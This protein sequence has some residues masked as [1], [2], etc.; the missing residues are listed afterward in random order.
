MF[1]LVG[2]HEATIADVPQFEPLAAVRTV[3]VGCSLHG[4]L[5]DSD[6]HELLHHRMPENDR[7]LCRGNQYLCF[8]KF[9]HYEFIE[10]MSNR[11][12]PYFLT[13]K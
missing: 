12:H 9:G 8:T 7:N 2:V 13:K 11:Q 6:Y 1:V 4:M 3:V 10:K 5:V